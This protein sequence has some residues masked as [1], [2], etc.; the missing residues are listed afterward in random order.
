MSGEFSAASHHQVRRSCSDVS[1]LKESYEL[2]VAAGLDND[3]ELVYWSYK[4]PYGGAFRQAGW[5]F[6]E[7]LFRFGVLSKPD[8]PEF[9]CDSHLYDDPEL[10]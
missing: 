3:I 10:P 2:Q 4:M 1:G 6:Q 5:S 9:D 8:T 7:L